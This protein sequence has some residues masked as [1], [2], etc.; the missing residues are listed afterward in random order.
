MPGTDVPVR[1]DAALTED[2]REL[3]VAYLRTKNMHE[4][5]S[6]IT[7]PGTGNYP[8]TNIAI[9]SGQVVNFANKGLYNGRW[10]V[11][12]VKHTLIDSK[13]VTELELHRCIDSSTWQQ[14]SREQL[15]QVKDSDTGNPPQVPSSGSDTG[16]VGLPGE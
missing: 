14:L 1:S 13:L 4:Y 7:F 15:A 10:I 3:A 5:R 9:V 11:E 12:V 2:E 8:G 6:T 16:I